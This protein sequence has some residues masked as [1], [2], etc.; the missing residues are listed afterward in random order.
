MMSDRGLG[1]TEVLVFLGLLA[2]V[3]GV[4]LFTLAAAILH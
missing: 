1:K 3:S 4:S 2:V